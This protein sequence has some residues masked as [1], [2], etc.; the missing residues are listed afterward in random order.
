MP[1]LLSIFVL[2]ALLISCNSRKRELNPVF[3]AIPGKV[4]IIDDIAR[5]GNVDGEATGY[6][7]EKSDQYKRY[8]W[9]KSKKS[10]S[11][12]LQLTDHSSPA[13]RVYAFCALAERNSP[14][15]VEI[16]EKHKYDSASFM[17]RGGCIGMPDQVNECFQRITEGRN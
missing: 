9:L 5:D 4:S 15:L 17:S 13:V 11:S 12:L 8:E 1:K 2:L 6:G 3:P 10:D 14:L 16:A 7:G